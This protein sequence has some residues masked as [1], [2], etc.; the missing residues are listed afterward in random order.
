MF[1]SHGSVLVDAYASDISDFKADTRKLTIAGAEYTTDA[2][3][4][5]VRPFDGDLID[6]LNI[7]DGIVK[8][9]NSAGSLDG[10]ARIKPVDLD[11][12]SAKTVSEK[13]PQTPASFKAGTFITFD[14]SGENF[15]L[16]VMDI[17]HQFESLS[18]ATLTNTATPAIDTATGTVYNIN[19]K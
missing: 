9:A 12:D 13:K 16:I 11:G 15:T 4:I 19:I 5:A 3:T 1:V 14:G 18:K 10:A 8:T 7:K 6:G 2:R 17:N